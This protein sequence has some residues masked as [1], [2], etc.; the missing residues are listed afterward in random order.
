M[1]RDTAHLLNAG[2]IELPVTAR[3]LARQLGRNE[4]LAGSDLDGYIEAKRK[5]ISYH[6]GVKGKS[7]PQPDGNPVNGLLEM[8]LSAER[9]HP[10]VRREVR[11]LLAR[12]R[13][14]SRLHGVSTES[15]AR[16]MVDALRTPLLGVRRYLDV[17]RTETAAAHFDEA[18]IALR[19]A[20][21]TLRVSGASVV[22]RDEWFDRPNQRSRGRI[23]PFPEV[24]SSYWLDVHTI[25]VRNWHQSGA[26]STAR[27]ALDTA[28]RGLLRLGHDRVAKNAPIWQVGYLTQA[29]MQAKA[30]L[31]VLAGE[32]PDRAADGALAW[33]ANLRLFDSGNDDFDWEDVQ[34]QVVATLVRLDRLE[35]ASEAFARLTAHPRVRTG[36]IA[37]VLD[38]AAVSAVS[39]DWKTVDACLALVPHPPDGQWDEDHEWVEP[40][41][42][43]V[44]AVRYSP[45]VAAEVLLD[46]WVR[47]VVTERTSGSRWSPPLLAGLLIAALDRAGAPRAATSRG[48]DALRV[49]ADDGWPLTARLRAAWQQRADGLRPSADDVLEGELTSVHLTRLLLKGDALWGANLTTLVK[50]LEKTTVPTA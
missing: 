28:A 47:L 49:V 13:S 38:F 34:A 50:Y 46:V 40:Q 3:A 10:P 41:R 7:L 11:D 14:D 43:D 24:V 23:F 2:K 39:G 9:L 37:A 36:V 20:I 18:M 33:G 21:A 12:A 22:P 19:A 6:W 32:P 44:I 29:W 45:D 5:L 48:R 30:E 16:Q 25:A 26:L 1:V 17:A 42:S 4:G 8:T 35:E 15:P 31:S 27:L